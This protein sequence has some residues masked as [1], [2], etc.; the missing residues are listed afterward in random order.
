MQEYFVWAEIVLLI[1]LVNLLVL[2]FRHNTYPRVIHVPVTSGPLAWTF[3]ALYWNGA[4]A[5][6]PYMDDNFTK[7][8][9]IL[10]ITSTWG[11]LIFGW[12]FL[13]LRNVSSSNL[14]SSFSRLLILKKDYTLTL[15]LSILVASLGTEQYLIH[16]TVWQWS[17]AFAIMALLYIP[18]L[19]V[20][21]PAAFG[22]ELTFRRKSSALLQD[23]QESTERA[24]LLTV[25]DLE[26][27]AS[28]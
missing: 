22:K 7:L 10:G 11:I 3:I 15:A 21:V 14:A 2:Y 25:P 12:A 28:C 18:T 5:L 24:P 23:L 26:R 1:N 17:S 13:F 8:A 4:I 9:F 19:F 20:G 16:N 6:Q 27:A